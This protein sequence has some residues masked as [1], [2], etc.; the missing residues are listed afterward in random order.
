MP[1]VVNLFGGGFYAVPNATATQS[2]PYTDG[3]L[4]SSIA[5]N[6]ETSIT[7]TAITSIDTTAAGVKFTNYYRHRVPYQISMAPQIRA[8]C[9]WVI[10]A[11]SPAGATGRVNV[12]VRRA[13]AAGNITSISGVTKGSGAPRALSAAPGTVYTDNQIVVDVP[14]QSFV[15]N[16]ALVILVEFEVLAT[17]AGNSLAVSLRT[18]PVTLGDE[19]VIEIDVGQP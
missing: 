5:V 6:R 12:D 3:R 16:E 9:R 15:P 7:L 19:L 4:I 11:S 17:G 8:R 13:D 2:A 18:D 1:D 14:T 10:A